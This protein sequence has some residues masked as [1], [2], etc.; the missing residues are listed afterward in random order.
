[1][2]ED[3]KMSQNLD[4]SNWDGPGGAGGGQNGAGGTGAGGQNG[5][6]APD[7]QSLPARVGRLEGEL[8]HLATKAD[9]EKLGTELRGEM[10]TLDTNLRKEIGG[11]KEELTAKIDGVKDDLSEKIE[12]QGKELAGISGQLKILI[13]VIGVVGGGLVGGLFT[14]ALRLPQ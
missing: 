1:M 5:D 7:A 3:D 12:A 13:W 2:K 11:V 9:L 6:G 8:K 14:L 4:G 10:H